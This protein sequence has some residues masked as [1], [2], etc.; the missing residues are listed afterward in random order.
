VKTSVLSTWLDKVILWMDMPL[1]NFDGNKPKFLRP[2]LLQHGQIPRAMAGV[3]PRTVLG[4]EWWDIERKKAYVAN[5]YCCWACGD[6]DNGL[7]AH[8]AYVI[9]YVKYTMTFVEVVAL[10]PAC[11]AFIHIGLTKIKKTRTE[12]RKIVDH[13][14]RILKKAKL[15]ANWGINLILPMEDWCWKIRR[16]IETQPPMSRYSWIGWHL[17]IA[18]TKYPPK[19]RNEEEADK[20]YKEHKNE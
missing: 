8:E 6:D 16:I 12:F 15:K 13:G 19:F 17:V 11:H 5:N 14:Y 4:Q 7:E 1:I 9:D 3:A 2:D 10:C 20:F 18:G